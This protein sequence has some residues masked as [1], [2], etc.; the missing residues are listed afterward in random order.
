MAQQLNGE[1]E[2]R[3]SEHELHEC[4]KKTLALMNRVGSTEHKS[5]TRE[6]VNVYPAINQINKNRKTYPQEWKAYNMAQQKEKLFLMD[7]LDELLSYVSFPQNKR[8]GRNPVAMRDKVFY[9][10]MQCYNMKSSRRCI[11]DLIIAKKAGYISKAP[12]FNTVLKIQKDATVTPCLKHLIQFSGLPLHNIEKD[13]A[14]DSSGFSTS[15]FGRWFDARTEKESDKRLYKKAHITCGVITNIV[16]AVTITSGTCNDSPEF[17]R[18][19]KETKRIFNPREVSADLGYISINNLEFALDNGI[20][21]FIPFKKNVNENSSHHNG[22]IWK[23]MLKFF[24]EYP[25]EF[26]HHYHKR[27]NVETTFQMIKRKFGE[28]LRSRTEKGQT[29]EILTKCLCHN[30]CVLVQELFELNIDLND[31][32]KYAEIKTAHK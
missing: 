24:T 29:N 31:F 32:K 20:I 22:M 15:I 23:K 19:I 16:S 7:I 21:P 30:L 8:A 9:L 14:V 3:I 5:L 28:H 10:I 1:C 26:Y 12:H 17:P 11:S 6:L 4:V 18:L 2:A 13:F 25:D 27:S